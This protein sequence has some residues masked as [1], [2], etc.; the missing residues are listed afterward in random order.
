MYQRQ[1]QIVV[2][3]FLQLT[4]THKTHNQDDTLI[5][6]KALIE[7]TRH[8]YYIHQLHHITELMPKYQ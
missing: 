1:E 6:N 8:N 5:T 7:I 2:M 4:M 3:I